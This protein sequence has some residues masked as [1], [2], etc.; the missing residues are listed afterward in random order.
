[1]ELQKHTAL[2]HEYMYLLDTKNK[3]HLET[4]FKFKNKNDYFFTPAQAQEFEEN[5]YN[6]LIEHIDS[7]TLIIYPQTNNQ[8][9]L[10]LIDKFDNN[11]Q[12]LLKNTP[13][14]I[15]NILSEQQMMK[16]E[17][18]KLFK[19]IESHSTVKMANIAGNQR[20]RFINCLFQHICIKANAVFL[21]DS[22]FSGYTLAAAYQAIQLDSQQHTL[23]SIALFSK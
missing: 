6:T 19:T 14:Q 12:Q 2:N 22:V 17:K 23:K 10:N 21:D 20:K 16:A 3:S 4:Y 9:F 7:K 15:L 8:L 1:M 5:V 18:E 11:K 13:Q